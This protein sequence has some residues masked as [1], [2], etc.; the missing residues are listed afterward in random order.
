MLPNLRDRLLC[1]F[2]SVQTDGC[3]IGICVVLNEKPQIQKRDKKPLAESSPTEWVQ[4]W[5]QGD[6]RAAE[7]LYDRYAEQLARLAA[8][9]LQ[10]KMARRVSGED[11]VQSVFQSFFQRTADNKLQVQNARELWNLLVT[12]TLSKTR[13]A[14]RH[15]R[16]RKRTVSAEVAIPQSEWLPMELAAGPSPSQAA[17]FVEEVQRL[18]EDLPLRHQEILSLRMAGH[19]RTEIAGITGL[20]RQTIYRVLKLIE[21]RISEL[22]I[23]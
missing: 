15:H 4:R 8:T 2:N 3:C 20:S 14:A 13:S 1:F 18:T 10:D 16:A 22:E 6:Q 23:D 5:Q 12:I 9:R 7:L 19:T 17:V 11:I 21:A